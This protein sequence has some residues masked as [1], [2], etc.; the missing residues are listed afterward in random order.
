M[1]K[2]PKLA[3]IVII[4]CTSYELHPEIL[5]CRAPSLSILVEFE[6]EINSKRRKR[7][8]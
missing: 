7:E 4:S 8:L 2:Y 5:S 3:K 6:E 1:T